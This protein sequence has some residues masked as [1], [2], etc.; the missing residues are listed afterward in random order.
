MLRSSM[1]FLVRRRRHGQPSTPAVPTDWSPR[2][3]QPSQPQIIYLNYR[4]WFKDTL[5]SAIRQ[6]FCCQ[7]YIESICCEDAASSQSGV[8]CTHN[9][10]I[11]NLCTDVI[12]LAEFISHWQTD[13][14]VH[15]LRSTCTLLIWI[16]H[17]STALIDLV[18]VLSNSVT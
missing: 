6:L 5:A 13:R 9:I 18:L 16:E 17:N 7:N 11:V 12:L 4:H 3:C 2:P 1:H 15:S 10:M 8:H 14:K